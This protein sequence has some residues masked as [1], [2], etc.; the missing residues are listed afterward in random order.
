MNLQQELIKQ[1]WHES[2][3]GWRPLA[4]NE[5]RESSGPECS[6]K[7]FASKIYPAPDPKSVEPQLKQLEDDQKNFGIF[8]VQGASG[9]FGTFTHLKIQDMVKPLIES[10][11]KKVT[12]TGKTTRRSGHVDMIYDDDVHGRVVCDI[13]SVSSMVFFYC[14]NLKTTQDPESY[15]IKK[16][17]ESIIQANSYAVRENVE[18][19]CILW[20]NRDNGMMFLEWFKAD[21]AMDKDIDEKNEDIEAA[22][23]RYVAGDAMARPKFC[24]VHEC[25]YC[26]HSAAY[27]DWDKSPFNCRGEDSARE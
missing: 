17:K 3:K 22:R 24:G 5:T 2:S 12:K 27:T 9:V 10:A 1:M 21:P 8:C 18:W 11:E 15:S 23:Q 7:L 13:K 26:R 4:N 25:M 6:Y 14:I 16:R 19:Y 20:V